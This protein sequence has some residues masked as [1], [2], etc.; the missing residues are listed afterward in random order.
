LAQGRDPVV[1]SDGAPSTV[2]AFGLNR[3]RVTLLVISTEL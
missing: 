3:S 1:T 2:P